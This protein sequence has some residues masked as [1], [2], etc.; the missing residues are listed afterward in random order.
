MTLNFVSI[1]IGI[2]AT[3]NYIPL[4]A[5]YDPSPKLTPYPSF[6]GNQLGDCENGLT[7]VYRIKAD[8]CDRLW[9]LDVGTYGYGKYIIF[10]NFTVIWQQQLYLNT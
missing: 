8:K 9:I 1:V 2:P 5:T 7:T 4:D 3:L 6:K 10:I